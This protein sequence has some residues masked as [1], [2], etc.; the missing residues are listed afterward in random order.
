M[1]C[2]PDGRVTIRRDPDSSKVIRVYF[3]LQELSSAILMYIDSTGL[4]M[5]Y[6]TASYCRIS[7]SLHLKASYTIVVNIVGLKVTLK[8][9][10]PDVYY[11]KKEHLTR[12]ERFEDLKKE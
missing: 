11:K 1:I 10:V 7:T 4:S 5:M 3:V 12:I 8:S 9:V 2:L 6:F